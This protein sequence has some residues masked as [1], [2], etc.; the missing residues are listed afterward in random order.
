LL[1]GPAIGDGARIMS[2][3]P[4]IPRF[5]DS[6]SQR[7]NRA[8]AA[9]GF[10]GFAFLKREAV[11]RMADRL[12]LMRRD[13]PLCLDFGC[14]DGM[15]TRE[16]AASG[17]VGQVI[18]ADPAPAF[19]AIAGAAG[20]AVAVEYDS[21]PFAAGSFDAV[22]SCLLL[23]WIDDLPGVMAQIRRLL[24]P[25]GLCLVSLL[26]GTTLTELRGALLE[27]EQELC[28]GA[29]PRTAPM[30]DIRDVGGLLGRA[31]L[32]LPVADSDRL[33]ITY[34][35]MFRLMADLRGMGEQNALLAR[36]R[37]PGQRQLFLRAAEIYQQRFATPDGRI[38]A[39]F[40]IITLTGWAPHESQQTPLRPG[41]AAHRLADELGTAEQD[42]EA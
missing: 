11:L 2:E 9:P 41:S 16:I 38:P 3:A 5:F 26:G 42:P 23:H 29:S 40:E 22:F 28:G 13:F 18:Q 31:G 6:A 15:L 12:A 14:H 1:F 35:D 17:K 39:S 34:P 30:A 4:T 25:D 37:T 32:A 21:L 24:K 8:R 33:T 7:R 36:S 20:P 19:A 27:A 10:A